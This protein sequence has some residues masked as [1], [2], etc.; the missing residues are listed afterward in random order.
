[1]LMF[2]LI[3]LCISMWIIMYVNHKYIYTASINSSRFKFF[4]LRD[5]LAIMAM[6]GDIK[7]DAMEYKYL[8]RLINTLITVTGHFEVIDYIRNV[9]DIM[10][11]PEAVKASE[12]IKKDILN[13]STGL[14]DIYKEFY[15]EFYRV[16]D[17]HLRPFI[18]TSTIVCAILSSVKLSLNFANRLFIAKNDIQAYMINAKTEA[19]L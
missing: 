2:N 8:L 5:R 13:H 10:N 16:G 17:R 14:R 12:I 4:E 15:N 6:K 9:R 3:V 18:I 19:N 1:M 7:E 11:F